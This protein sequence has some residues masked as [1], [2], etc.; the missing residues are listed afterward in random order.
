MVRTNPPSLAPSIVLASL[1]TFGLGSIA[2]VNG[3]DFLA[4]AAE[5][6]NNGPSDEYI[7]GNKADPQGSDA[8]CTG[9]PHDFSQPT[10]NPHDFS[11][12]NDT[13]NPHECFQ[14]VIPE[15][16]IGSI[17]LIM[18]A[19]GSLGGFLALKSRIMGA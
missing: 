1:L 12:G 8:A 4:F 5:D 3:N 7:P 14:F 10:G 17:A 11:E 19:V 2:A 18:S 6:N 16:P 15:S 9:N 13:G